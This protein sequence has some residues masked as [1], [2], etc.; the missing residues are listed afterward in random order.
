[1]LTYW[2]RFEA[3]STDSRHHHGQPS[4]LASHQL[5]DKVPNFTAPLV[6]HLCDRGYFYNVG[7]LLQY[8]QRYRIK[9]KQLYLYYVWYKNKRAFFISY[10]PGGS[11]GVSSPMPYS[12]N[13]SSGPNVEGVDCNL[14]VNE[15]RISMSRS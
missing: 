5:V 3:L 2:Q 1:M 15:S 9:T 13:P 12:S 4:R 14:L 7:T 8:V 11:F 6:F 10:R